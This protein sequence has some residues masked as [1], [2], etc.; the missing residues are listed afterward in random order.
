MRQRRPR[1]HD[2]KH[3]RFVRGRLC[4]VCGDNTSVEAAHIRMADPRIGKPMVGMG[5]K[6]DDRYTVPLCSRCHQDQHKHNERAWWAD[7]HRDPI[8]IALALHSHS[9]DQEM[10]ETIV[11]GY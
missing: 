10:G 6:P 5:E 3:L 8:L 1:V 7:K 4:L 9:G 11:R 2:P